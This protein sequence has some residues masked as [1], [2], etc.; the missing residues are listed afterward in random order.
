MK[1]KGGFDFGE[2]EQSLGGRTL[3]A[4]SRQKQRMGFVL[5]Q[6]LA[7]P[8]HQNQT[9][10]VSARF[11]HKLQLLRFHAVHRTNTRHS[12]QL[13]ICRGVS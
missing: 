4:L 12:D 2:K 1:I 13:K 3:E 6:R 5:A 7:A 10:S 11:L 9:E 8:T